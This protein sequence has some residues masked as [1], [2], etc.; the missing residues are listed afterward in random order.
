MV[1]PLN[2][3]FSSCWSSWFSI[4]NIVTD[5]K[6]FY[7]ECFFLF[8]YHSFAH[9]LLNHDVTEFTISLPYT[10]SYKLRAKRY[11]T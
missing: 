4:P 3:V 5:P 9:D 10:Y 11:S 6:L 1:M 8:F 7:E 2:G